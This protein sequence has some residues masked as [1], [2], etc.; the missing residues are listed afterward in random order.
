MEAVARQYAT[1]EHVMVIRNGVSLFHGKISHDVS[2]TLTF[3][4]KLKISNSG[5][6]F[7]GLRFLIW[8]VKILFPSRILCLKL[9]Q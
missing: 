4:F 8:V 7:V 5:F 1:N 6:L 9:N 2:K 3:L